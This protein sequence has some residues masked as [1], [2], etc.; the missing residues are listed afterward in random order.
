MT[1][2]NTTINNNNISTL[3]AGS[4]GSAFAIFVA[5]Y[6]DINTGSAKRE[7]KTAAQSFS[8]SFLKY[9]T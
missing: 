2:T 5:A 7:A 6:L 3:G 1:S 4:S 8:R 9:Q